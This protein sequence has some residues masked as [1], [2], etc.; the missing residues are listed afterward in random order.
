E[1][2]FTDAHGKSFLVASDNYNNFC[3]TL[4]KIA[5]PYDRLH[6]VSGLTE[7]D[8]DA[9]HQN[10]SA[11]TVDLI[12]RWKDDSEDRTERLHGMLNMTQD[13][14]QTALE[15]QSRQQLL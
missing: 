9:Y 14:L 10:L 3:N 8:A 13:L 11:C 4:R 15:P 6:R 2:A 7:H 12:K 5:S 1:K